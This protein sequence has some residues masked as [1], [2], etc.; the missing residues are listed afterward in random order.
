MNKFLIATL[1]VLPLF[2]QDPSS[3]PLASDIKQTY[4]KLCGLPRGRCEGTQQGPG[5]AGNS[6]VRRRSAQSLRNVI[7]N[8]IPAA[9]MPAFDLPA[10]TIEALASL[11]VSLNASAAESR[12][13]AIGR[14]KGILLWQGTM[15]FLPHG[16]RRGRAD[17]PGPVDVSRAK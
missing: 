15:R 14:R 1:A 11:V 2:A 13:R 12:C 5:L 6:W 9:G 4:A 7:R 16:L 8:G 17:W 3:P 10:P